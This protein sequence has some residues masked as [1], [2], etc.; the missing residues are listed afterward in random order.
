MKELEKQKGLPLTLQLLHANKLNEEGATSS[1]KSIAVAPYQTLYAT[2]KFH[3]K[4]ISK[5][6]DYSKL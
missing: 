1:I 6:I 3:Y 2:A 4:P 5:L